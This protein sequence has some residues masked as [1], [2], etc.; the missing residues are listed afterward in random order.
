M[1][2]LYSYKKMNGSSNSNTDHHAHT[3]SN[4]Q[5]SNLTLPSQ[6]SK[7][8][9]PLPLIKPLPPAPLL[10]V[11]S[12]QIKFQKEYLSPN[13]QFRVIITEYWSPQLPLKITVYDL[14]LSPNPIINK[15][16]TSYQYHQDLLSFGQDNN[17]T[18]IRLLNPEIIKL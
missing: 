6:V 3:I 16:L 12:I 13:K 11:E 2:N 18:F 5:T 10:P 14:H 15:F 7:I 1:G 8:A 17:Q 9:S 4:T